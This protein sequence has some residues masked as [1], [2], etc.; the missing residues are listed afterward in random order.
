MTYD[1]REFALKQKIA[2]LESQ[3]TAA[4]TQLET[5]VCTEPP[6]DGVILISDEAT[7]HADPDTGVSTYNNVHFTPLGD[8]LMELWRILNGS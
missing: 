7:F 6:D 8:A 4:R 1:Q 5:I 3:L 2:S